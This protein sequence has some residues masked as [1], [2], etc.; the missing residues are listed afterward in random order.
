VSFSSN[1]IMMRMPEEETKIKRRSVQ[2]KDQSGQL[3]ARTFV[4]TNCSF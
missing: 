3:V 1:R 2:N 4:F